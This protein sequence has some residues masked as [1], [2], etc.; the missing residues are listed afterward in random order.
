MPK[1]GQVNAVSENETTELK[2]IVVDDIKKEII[3]FANCG[4]G[5]LYV[6]VRDNGTVA[7]LSASDEAALQISNMVRDA[8]KPDLTMLVPWGKGRGVRYVLGLEGSV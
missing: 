4:G 8:V 6:G 5:R 3:A 2:E 1:G 7:G